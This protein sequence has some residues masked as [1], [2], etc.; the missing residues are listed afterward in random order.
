MNENEWKLN[1]YEGKWNYDDD[2]YF[3][4]DSQYE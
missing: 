2:S 1:W 3:E 4:V